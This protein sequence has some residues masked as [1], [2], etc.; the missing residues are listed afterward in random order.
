VP[1]RTIRKLSDDERQRAQYLLADGLEPKAVAKR[2]GVDVRSL[3][4]LLESP[5]VRD[6]S[7]ADRFQLVFRH[8]WVQYEL[9]CRAADELTAAI[10]SDGAHNDR[11]RHYADSVR[12]LRAVADRHLRTAL[13]AAEKI[14]KLGGNLAEEFAGLTVSINGAE[15]G[16]QPTLAGE[17]VSDDGD[18]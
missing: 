15:L 13:E 7:D 18:A 11:D 12:Q 9:N 10:K 4:G 2:L 17:A 5:I 16:D 3:N 14:A 1:K 8:S 6:L